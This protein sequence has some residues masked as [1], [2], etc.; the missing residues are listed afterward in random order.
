MKARENAEIKTLLQEPEHLEKPGLL[1]DTQK[2]QKVL[3][4]IAS[5]A[6][7]EEVTATLK[8]IGVSTIGDAVRKIS[9]EYDTF[10]KTIRLYLGY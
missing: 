2:I 1:E 10:K 4:D 9:I 6:S 8:N 5:K 3:D 7:A